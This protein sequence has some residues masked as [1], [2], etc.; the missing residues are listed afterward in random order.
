MNKPAADLP[1]R[2][3]VNISEFETTE[4]LQLPGS[5]LLCNTA[6]GKGNQYHSNSS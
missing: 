1:Q 3:A 4:H 5:Q 6:F 2:E